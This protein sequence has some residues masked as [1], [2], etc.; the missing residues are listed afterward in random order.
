MAYQVDPTSGD[1]VINGFDKGIGASP[2]TGLTDLKSVDIDG[3]PGE[4]SV[5]FSTSAVSPT[6]QLTALACTLSNSFDALVYA[7]SNPKL[8]DGQAVSFADSGGGVTAGVVYWVFLNSTSGG[9]YHFFLYSD[10]PMGSQVSITDASTTV[11][12]FNV[13]KAKFFSTMSHGEA[14]SN[15]MI[16]A[17]GQIWSDYLEQSGNNLWR[18]T[19]NTP[20]AD[21]HGNGLVYW[22]TS[23]NYASSGKVGDWDGYLLSFRDGFIDYSNTNGVNSGAGYNH[24]GTYT[25]GWNP[26]TGST[27]VAS[28]Y[29]TGSNLGS[30]PHNAIA[31]PDGRVYFCDYYNVRKISQADVITPT[32]FSTAVPTTYNYTNYNL[33][34]INDIATCIAPLGTDMLI[35]GTYNQAYA[36]DT[37]SN[38]ISYPILLSES[39]V[40]NIITVNTNAFLFTG[41]RGTIYITNGSQAN[42]W[43]K[44]PDHISNT[45]EP[46]F[47]WGGAAYNKNRL[48]FGINVIDNASANISGYG[49][50][51]CADL[52]TGALWLSNQ[53]SYGTYVGYVSALMAL[54]PTPVFSG[55]PAEPAG[56]GY[57][58]GWYNG[59]NSQSYGIDT[60]VS[61]VY[62]GTQSVVI[63]DMIPVGTLLKPTTASQVEFKLAKPL[64]SGET[65]ELQV[66]SSLGGTFTSALIVNGDATGTILSGNSQNMPIQ[67]QQ[68]MLVKAI[69]TGTLGTPTYNRITELRIV[70]ATTAHS[71]TQQSGIQ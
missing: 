11:T 28:A 69:L 66:A 6:V 24:V 34:P 38:V 60:T 51:W 46:Y 54:P 42:P 57:L 22:R 13:A 41:N 30:C 59:L 62:T 45:V 23:R 18:Y 26:A 27:G 68:W 16:D 52:T 7:T 8:A 39:Y 49:G 64:G 55:F 63:S 58:A 37:F 56:V 44:I 19:G 3:V 33:L 17:S 36:W 35:G 71:I 48:Y 4:V 1:I 50:V 21:G 40:A 53:M 2:Y 61:A 10:Y 47:Q 14:G 65:V 15:F 25:Y 43:I 31:G 32:T 67:Q 5:N 12:T 9:N 20:G 29:L 70:G